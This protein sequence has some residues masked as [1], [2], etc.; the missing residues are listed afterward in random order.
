VLDDETKKKLAG[1]LGFE[2]SATFKYVP[3]VFR[4]GGV[5]KSL[6]PVFTLK[7]KD[8]LEI[9][10]AE[11][12]AGYVELDNRNKLRMETG[13]QRVATLERGIVSVDNML[14]ENGDVVSYTTASRTMKTRAAG[15]HESVKNCDVKALIRILPARL[16][17]ELQEAINERSVLSP[18][19]LSGL[20]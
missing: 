10:R 15:G 9:A 1:F 8:G 11:D 5:D 14:M 6:W 3:K 12:E 13:S 16:Q 18:E 4:S 7:S 2:V 19:E 20:G 17:V